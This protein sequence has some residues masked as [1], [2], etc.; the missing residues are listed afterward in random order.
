[1]GA[2]E[3]SDSDSLMEVLRVPEKVWFELH[4]EGDACD[5]IVRMEDGSFFTALFVTLPY[6]QRQMQLSYEMTRNFPDTPAV[7][8]AALDTPHIVVDA[9]ETTIIEDTI[10]NLLALDLFE[11]LFTRVTEDPRKDQGRTTENGRLATQEV[12]AVVVSD[13]LVCKD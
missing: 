8:Y 4:R 13:V 10:D 9:L 6:L 11:S 5:A 7:R 1:M 3:H 12:A 2:L